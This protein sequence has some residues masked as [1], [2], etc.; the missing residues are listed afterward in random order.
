MQVLRPR[1]RV[2]PGVTGWAASVVVAAAAAAAA[3]VVVVTVVVVVVVVALA[4]SVAPQAGATR[5][6]SRN[7]LVPR[8][9][10]TTSCNG[11]V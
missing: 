11:F 6:V 8:P 10:G 9:L 2:E 3:L 5:M 4:V 7:V 1:M